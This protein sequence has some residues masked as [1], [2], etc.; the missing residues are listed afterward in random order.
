MPRKRTIESRIEAETEPDDQGEEIADDREKVSAERMFDLAG[1]LPNGK[2]HVSRLNPRTGGYAMVGTLPTN[3]ENPVSW[4]QIARR[5]GGGCYRW[6]ARVE[7][8]YHSSGSFEVD[9]G[10]FPNQEGR[11]N[12]P[13]GLTSGGDRS[14]LDVVMRRLDGMEAR[15][16]AP[17]APPFGIREIMEMVTG[18]LA[19][20]RSPEPQGM[21]ADKLLE[22]LRTGI[23][24][25]KSASGEGKGIADVIAEV[26]PRLLE[27]VKQRNDMVFQRDRQRGF[28]PGGAVRKPT[29]EEIQKRAVMET[30]KV[31][32]ARAKAGA[33]PAEVADYAE[34]AFP[35]IVLETLVQNPPEA[36]VKRL[37]EMVPGERDWLA[38]PAALEWTRRFVALFSE[39]QGDPTEETDDATETET[40]GEPEEEPGATGTDGPPFPTP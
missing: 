15:L 33:D 3:P 27:V 39:T 9:P 23:D 40:E 5:W 14:T 36:I 6:E 17:A 38:T 34:T 18:L 35:A 20:T 30:V 8:R 11:E 1:A 32:I 28:A 22:A 7:G 16:A 24:L 4:E 10:T 12:L 19:V 13:E 26:G 21:G 31:I 29:P 25:G 2:L 37:A